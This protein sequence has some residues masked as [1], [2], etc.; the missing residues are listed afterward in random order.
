MSSSPDLEA[1]AD[2]QGAERVGAGEHDS[3]GRYRPRPGFVMLM[4]HS[5]AYSGGGTR[6]PAMGGVAR[7]GFGG[8][9]KATGVGG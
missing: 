8:I 5:P 6:S 4:A 1:K 7:G 9:A 2:E 3:T